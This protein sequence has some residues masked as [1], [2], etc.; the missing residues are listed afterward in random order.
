MDGSQTE[1]GRRWREGL[2]AFLAFGGDNEADEDD[3]ED[4]EVRK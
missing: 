4:D 3:E 1:R 2:L